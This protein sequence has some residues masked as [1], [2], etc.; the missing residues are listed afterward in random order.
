MEINIT[1]FFKNAQPCLYS[2]SVAETGLQ[3]IGAHTWSKAVDA[4]GE[5]PIITTDEQREAFKAYAAEFGAW[6]EVERNAWSHEEINALAIQFV[7]SVMREGG[8]D[9]ADPDWD[10]YLADAA[11]GR[12]DSLLFRADNGDVYADFSH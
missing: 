9:V 8:L 2:A 6:D 10:A 12:V 1:Q 3:N 11:A 4:F 5:F 7:S